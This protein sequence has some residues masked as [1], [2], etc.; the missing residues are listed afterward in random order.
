MKLIA[1]VKR[2]PSTDAQ[3][4]I[5]AD[6]KSLD[7]TGLQFML[8]FYDEI[9]VEQAVLLKE[10]HGGEVTVLSLGPSDVQKELRE[11]LAKGADSAV[12]LK[13]EQWAARDA[14]STAKAIAAKL[15]TLGAD[16]I[17]AGR[18]ATDRDNAAVGPMIAAELGIACVTDVIE[19][20]IEN[21]QGLAKRESEA[22]IETYRFPLPALVTCQKGLAEPRLSNLKGIMAAKKKPLEEVAA[23]A[24]PS[25]AQVVRLELPP[26]RPAGRILGEGAAAVPE[27]IEA[28]SNQSKVL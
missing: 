14:R 27:L 11:C 12:I 3:A 8:S 26:A 28:L 25:Q 13:D 4:R 24:V 17:L 6:G 15:K 9:A 19:L 21:G 5:A 20:S 22:G 10:K 23:E 1:L 2:V 18:V 16:L 7:Q